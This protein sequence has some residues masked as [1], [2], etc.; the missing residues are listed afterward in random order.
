MIVAKQS[1]VTETTQPFLSNESCEKLR[2]NGYDETLRF[3][4]KN[5]GAQ[6]SKDF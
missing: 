1:S 3:F 4:Q 6:K 2:E 5:F